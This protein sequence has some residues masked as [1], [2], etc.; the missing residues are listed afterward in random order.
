L[1][2]RRQQQLE[3]KLQQEH[4]KYQEIQLKVKKS[5]RTEKPPKLGT[6]STA[7]TLAKD[8]ATRGTPAKQVPPKK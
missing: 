5:V 1:P 8:V 7:G 2:H 4:Q 3:A 6:P